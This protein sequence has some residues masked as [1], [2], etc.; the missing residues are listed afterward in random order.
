MANQWF[1]MDTD[2]LSNYKVQSLPEAFRW[3]YVALLC[4]KCNGEYKH[5]QNDDDISWY[6]RITKESWI[7]SK[8]A[9]IEKSLITVDGEIVDWHK[10]NP[11]DSLRPQSDVWA[12]IRERIFERDDY[13]CQYCGDRGGKLECDHVHPVSLGGSHDDS[14]LLTACFKCNRSKA[15]KTLAQWKGE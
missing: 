2:I 13:T 14:N 15:G 4:L 7:E 6:L 5:L 12:K 1:R 8:T 9:F 11:S 10:F 3:R